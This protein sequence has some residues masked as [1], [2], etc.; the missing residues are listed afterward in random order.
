MKE[1]QVGDS[2]CVNQEGFPPVRIRIVS[3]CDRGWDA[4]QLTNPSG[5]YWLDREELESGEV[6]LSGHMPRVQ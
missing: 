1:L 4:W 2:V 6:T 3:V 5:G